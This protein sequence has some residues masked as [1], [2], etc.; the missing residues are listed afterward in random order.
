MAETTNTTD[1]SAYTDA[2]NQAVASTKD[3]G[4]STDYSVLNQATEGLTGSNEALGQAAIDNYKNQEAATKASAEKAAAGLE[5]AGQAQIAQAQNIDTLKEQVAA[6]VASASES[7][8]RAAGKAEEYVQKANK[9]VTD[10]LNKLDTINSEFATE[11]S[12]AKAHDMQVAAQSVLGSMQA[13]ERNILEVY[14]G[15]SK[16][17]E[18]FRQSKQT[19]LATAQS[20]IHASYQ[21]L[22]EEQQATYMSVVSDAYT[23]SNMYLGYQEQQH[24]EMI[25]YA[26]QAKASYELQATEMTFALEQAKTAGL[27]NLANWIVDTP[28]FTMDATPLITLLSDLQQTQAAQDQAAA[29]QAETD[30]TN[31]DAEKRRQDYYRQFNSVMR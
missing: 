11:R 17:Y 6:Q 25:K 15:D 18:Q 12:F 19:A 3:T 2:L 24:V 27:E 30:K 1:Y 14:G 16:E 21:K 5:L 29:L 4:T 31:A 23:K 20:N 26:D 9:R 7:W 28:T 10:V 13:E 22:A 8:D